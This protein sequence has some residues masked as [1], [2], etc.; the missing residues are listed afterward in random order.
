[1]ALFLL[2]F[3]P[4]AAGVGLTI[5]ANVNLKRLLIGSIL[6]PGGNDSA[7]LVCDLTQ[8]HCLPNRPEGRN[9]EYPEIR[10]R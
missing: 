8:L 6:I 3:F 1:M 2:T 4:H 9:L 10:L 7:G 5:Q